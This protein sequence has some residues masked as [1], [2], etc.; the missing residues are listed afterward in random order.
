MHRFAIRLLLP[1]TPQSIVYVS[2]DL[3]AL[4]NR[5]TSRSVLVYKRMIIILNTLF[6]V[7]IPLRFKL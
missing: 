7:P 1:W 2:V 6:V 5:L 3:K 4:E